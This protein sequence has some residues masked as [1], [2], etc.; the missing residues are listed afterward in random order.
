[1]NHKKE[2]EERKLIFIKDNISM[3]FYEIHIV[4]TYDYILCIAILQLFS[5]YMLQGKFLVDCTT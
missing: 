2:V 5:K 4:H 1:M 3:L